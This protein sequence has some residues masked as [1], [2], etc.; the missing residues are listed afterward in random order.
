MAAIED[1][2]RTSENLRATLEPMDEPE[3]MAQQIVQQGAVHALETLLTHGC[4]EQVAQDMLASLRSNM[5]VIEAV[6]RDKG[7]TLLFADD[8]AGVS[9]SDGQTDRAAPEAKG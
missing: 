4:T 6:A 3:L 9:A 7:Y 5:L 1:F 2:A 8:A